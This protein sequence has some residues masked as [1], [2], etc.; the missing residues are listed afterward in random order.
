MPNPAFECSC[1]NTTHKI[2]RANTKCIT[3]ERIATLEKVSHVLMNWPRIHNSL[4]HFYLSHQVLF[5]Q[6]Q[7]LVHDNWYSCI[8]HCHRLS[9]WFM[10]L[11]SY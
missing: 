7:Q 2:V 11:V 3:K 5:S 8:E 10:L 1:Q 4:E 9:E 6:A